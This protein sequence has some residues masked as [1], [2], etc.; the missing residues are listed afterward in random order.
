MNI[1]EKKLIGI[2]SF[3]S[4]NY[5]ISINA[6]M[7]FLLYIYSGLRG[8]IWYYFHFSRLWMCLMQGISFKG[9]RLGGKLYIKTFKSEF[10]AAKLT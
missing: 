7:C 10:L 5:K 9:D 3:C 1:D 2:V 4:N 6:I 8:K